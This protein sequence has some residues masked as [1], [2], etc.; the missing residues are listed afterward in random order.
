MRI[1]KEA[2]ILPIFLCGVVAI[3]MIS[4]AATSRVGLYLPFLQ[5]NFDGNG[6]SQTN[7]FSVSATNF[8]VAGSTNQI[9]FGATNTAPSD[10]ANIA[11]WISVQVAG[12]NVVYRIPV[13]K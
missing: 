7:F 10:P 5:S 12:S 11:T 13:Y 8:S 2:A 9:I 6:Y 1:A 3:A 4:L